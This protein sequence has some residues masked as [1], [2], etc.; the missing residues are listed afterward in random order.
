M[1]DTLRPDMDMGLEVASQQQINYWAIRQVVKVERHIDEEDSPDKFYWNCNNIVDNLATQAREIFTVEAVKKQPDVLLPGTK[2]GVVIGGRLVNND[3][4]GTL[5]EHINGYEMKQ[6]LMMNNSWTGPTFDSIDWDAHHNQLKSYSITKQV[7]VI[8]YIH[9][10]LATKRRRHR[11]GAISDNKCQLC[12]QEETRTHIFHCNNEQLKFIR[13]T[14]Q[15]TLWKELGKSTA[16][17]FQQVF[18][19]GLST[20]VGGPPT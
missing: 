4:Y 18:T 19:A 11:E 15:I 7:T 12:D 6:Y 13:E 5:K 10:W 20:A 14:K 8:K 16:E 9:G 1:K 3:I 2:A 17:G